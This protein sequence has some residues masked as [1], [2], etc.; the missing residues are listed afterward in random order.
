M[1]KKLFSIVVILIVVG[2]IGKRPKKVP[3]TFNF[4]GKRPKKVPDTFNFS[5]INA[6]T[7]VIGSMW[8]GEVGYF[9]HPPILADHVPDMKEG[10]WKKNYFILKAEKKNLNH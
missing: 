3:D 6:R 5:P 1:L 9:Y 2:L 8:T 10:I 7:C 4:S